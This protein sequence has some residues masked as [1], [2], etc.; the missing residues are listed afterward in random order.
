ME[1]LK[2][3]ER[4]GEKAKIPDEKL[5]VKIKE[6]QSNMSQL[7]ETYNVLGKV[8]NVDASKSIEETY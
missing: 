4:Y 3:E 8:Q 7:I 2:N 5:L 6:F 1:R